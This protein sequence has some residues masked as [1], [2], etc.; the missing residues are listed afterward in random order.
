MPYIEK[1][2]YTEEEIEAMLKAHY[3]GYIDVADYWK[4]GEV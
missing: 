1:F 2:I 3:E 4:I